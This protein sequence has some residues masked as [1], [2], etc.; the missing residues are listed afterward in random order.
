MEKKNSKF[1]IFIVHGNLNQSATFSTYPIR[2]SDLDLYFIQSQQ[3]TVAL[4]EDGSK[5]R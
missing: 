4:E 2:Y 1:L 3:G 5:Y